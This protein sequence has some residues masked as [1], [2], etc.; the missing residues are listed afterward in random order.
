MN[1]DTDRNNNRYDVYKWHY[2]TCYMGWRN[3]IEKLHINASVQ[4][5]PYGHITKIVKYARNIY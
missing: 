4:K 2:N 1:S 5:Y 3:M